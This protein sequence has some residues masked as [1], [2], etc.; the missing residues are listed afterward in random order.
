MKQLENFDILERKLYLDQVTPSL[1]KKQLFQI[2]PSFSKT[3]PYFRLPK[4][5]IG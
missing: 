1:K 5:E 2:C 4:V 3:C